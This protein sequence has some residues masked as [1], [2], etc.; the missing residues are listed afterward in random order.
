VLTVHR[1]ERWDDALAWANQGRYGLQ[2]AV[3]TRDVGR[4]HQAYRELDVGALIANE[5][6]TFRVDGMPYGGVRDSGLGREGVRYAIEE[7]TERKLLVL[8]A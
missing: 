1:Y 6:P 3:F 5:A 2:A 8:R 7:L 4:I